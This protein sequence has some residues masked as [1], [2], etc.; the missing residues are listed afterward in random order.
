VFYIRQHT[1][2]Y[3]LNYTFGDIYPAVTKT[4][5]LF[6]WLLIV[7]REQRFIVE[8]CIDVFR[9]APTTEDVISLVKECERWVQSLPNMIVRNVSPHTMLANLYTNM[10]T[11]EVMP[12]TPSYPL[13]DTDQFVNFIAHYEDLI[14][15][16]NALNNVSL[17]SVENLSNTRGTKP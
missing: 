4:L 17:F 10:I 6:H 3:P 2:K 11:T 12:K 16:Q 1:K 14:E 9:E 5:Y 13:P 15:A 8:S 7:F